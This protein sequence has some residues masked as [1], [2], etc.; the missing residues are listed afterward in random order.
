[1]QTCNIAAKKP[2]WYN[3]LW[4]CVWLRWGKWHTQRHI[5]IRD[6]NHYAVTLGEGISNAVRMKELRVHQKQIEQMLL[7]SCLK[8]SS[9]FPSHPLVLPTAA[10]TVSQKLTDQKEVSMYSKPGVMLSSS[11]HKHGQEMTF[12]PGVHVFREMKVCEVAVMV[13]IS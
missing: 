4:H 11:T 9:M 13:A 6:M 3:L 5:I 2:V 1:M 12:E 10:Y 7:T 8:S